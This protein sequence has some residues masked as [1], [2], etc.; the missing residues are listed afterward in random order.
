VRRKQAESE[1]IDYER[2]CEGKFCMGVCFGVCVDMSLVLLVLG[3]VAFHDWTGV[4]MQPL[5]A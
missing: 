5:S 1:Q 2:A 3:M 4:F